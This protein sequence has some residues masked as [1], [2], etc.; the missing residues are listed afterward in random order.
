MGV[1]L[2]DIIT[3]LSSWAMVAF[4]ALF[5]YFK[6]KGQKTKYR[7]GLYSLISLVIMIVAGFAFFNTPQGKHILKTG[8][9]SESVMSLGQKKKKAKTF[10]D[11]VQAITYRMKNTKTLFFQNSYSVVANGKNITVNITDKQDSIE[12]IKL[13]VADLLKQVKKTEYQKFDA[14]NFNIKLKK[15]QMK[16]NVPTS[17]LKVTANNKI[18]PAWIDKFQV[19]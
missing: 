12:S 16:Y 9:T 10:K 8:D 11:P 17:K 13:T 18:K 19:K 1:Q 3:K 2:L 14:I 15:G 7:F 6:I 4:F 5:V